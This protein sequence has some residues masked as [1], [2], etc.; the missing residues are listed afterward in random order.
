MRIKRQLAIMNNRSTTTVV[1]VPPMCKIVIV[2]V[3]GIWG[4]KLPVLQVYECQDE[5]GNP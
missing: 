2:N 4:M 3:N 1:H 5:R